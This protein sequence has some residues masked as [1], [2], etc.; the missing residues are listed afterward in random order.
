[1]SDTRPVAFTVDQAREIVRVYRS[2]AGQGSDLGGKRRRFV[3]TYTG[4]FRKVYVFQ[5]GGAAGSGT[6][7]ATWTYRMEDAAGNAL[8]GSDVTPVQ[9]QW[10]RPPTGRMLAA[11]DESIAFATMEADQNNM[12]TL[13]LVWV[14][15]VPDTRLCAQ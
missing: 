1:M 15:E 4:E 12:P 10:V 5:V 13:V 3:T 8:A 11:P 14:N 7:S 9:P 6:T 2:I